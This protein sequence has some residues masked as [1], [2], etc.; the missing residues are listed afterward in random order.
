[1]GYKMIYKDDRNVKRFAKNVGILGIFND[2][3]TYIPHI[4]RYPLSYMHKNMP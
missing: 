4:Q 3:R 2:I 1:M